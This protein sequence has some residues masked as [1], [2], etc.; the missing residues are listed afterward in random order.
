MPDAFSLNY[1]GPMSDRPR[2]YADDGSRDVLTL[3]PRTVEVENA[4]LRAQPHSLDREGF[5]LVAHQSAVA[6]FRDPQALATVYRLEMQQ[7]LLGLTGADEVVFSALPVCRSTR[8]ARLTVAKQFYNSRPGEFVHI[9]ISAATAVSLAKR[10]EPKHR[11]ERVRRFAHYNMW[12][13][14]SPPPQDVPLAVCDSRSVSPADLVEADAV[15]DIPGKREFSYVGLVI[16]YNPRH[17]WS[18]FARMN[19]DELLIFKAHD[20]DSSQP[21]Q[22]PHTAFQDPTCP[23][24]HVARASIEMRAIAYWYER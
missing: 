9:D 11:N 21:N 20:S 2:Y 4:R 5:T 22:V 1:I 10:C 3:D 7:L 24:G 12:R 6:D 13:A 16:R 14:F 23:P 15:M 8:G 19:R 18:W 17:R